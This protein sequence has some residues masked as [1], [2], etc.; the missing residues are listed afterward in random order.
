VAVA[1]AGVQHLAWFHDSSYFEQV[2]NPMTAAV[3]NVPA[4]LQSLSELWENGY[5]GSVRKIAFLAASA[6]AAFGYLRSLRASVSVFH[7]F[8]MLYLAPV[9]LWPSF[10][11]TRFLIPIVPFYFHHC[12]LAVGRMDAAAGRRW[13]TR[14]AVLV[15]FLAAVLVSYAGRYST[16]QFGPLQ[17]GIAKRESRE[18]LEFV[19]TSTDPTD[20]FVFSRPRA[21]ALLT[22]RRASGGF[23]PA[24][25]CR[26][27]QY[28]REIRA[29]HVITGPDPD[30]F[31]DD[32]VY[33]RRFVARFRNDF[34][35]V[36]ANEDL[37]VYRI[38]QDPCTPGSPPR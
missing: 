19:K 33:L 21:L 7:L 16:L 18:F 34:S 9:M 13:G 1:L 12:L 24:D 8:P 29:S 35:R 28:M 37:A 5:S 32:A 31:N 27:W 22:G 36:M 17:Q 26:L 4:Y 2:S 38:E 25:P 3:R 23:S 11:G 10:Q 14:H 15:V 6:L 20:V 30:P